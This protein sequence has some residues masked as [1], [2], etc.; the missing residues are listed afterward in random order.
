MPQSALLRL[1]LTAT[2]LFLAVAVIWWALG[3]QL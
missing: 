3:F 2:A 1:L